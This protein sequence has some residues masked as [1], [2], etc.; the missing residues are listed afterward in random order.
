M[1][2]A[3]GDNGFGNALDV[4]RAENRELS[5]SLSPKRSAAA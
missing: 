3:K 4:S 5:N 2:R 1:M